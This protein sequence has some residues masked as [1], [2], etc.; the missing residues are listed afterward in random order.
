MFDT[1]KLQSST[2]DGSTSSVTGEP[3]FGANDP[4]SELNPSSSH[5]NVRAWASN[6]AKVTL[7]GGSQFRRMGVCFQNL[8]AFGFITPADYQKDVANIWLALPGM[9]IRN[10]KRV[11]ILHQFDGIIRP[12]EMCVVLGPP[13]SGCSTFLKTLSGDRDGFFIGEDSYFNYEGIS[14]KELHTAHRGDAI[15]T[16]ET[17]VHFPKLTVSQTL[18]FAAQA[19]CPREIPQG[20]PRQQFCKQLKDVVMGMYGISHTADTKVGNDYIRGVSGG[21]RKRVTIAEATLS[22]APLQCWDN[23]TRGL[24]SANAIGFCKTLRLQSEF[25]GQS[26]AVS[27]YQAPQSAYDLFD[28]ATVLYQGHQIYFGPADEAKAYFE[29]LGFECPSRQTTPDFLTSMTFPEERITRAG[30]NPPR[31]PEEFAAA[32]RS[33]PEYKAL[34]TDISEYKTKHPIDGPNAGV[35]RELKKSY[36]A[37]GQRIKSPY[38]L[39]YMQQVQMCMR[40]AWNRLVSDPGPTIVVTM[41]N[42]VLALIMSSLFFNMQPDTDSFYGREVVLFMAVMFNAFASV[43]EVMTLYAQR[44]IV[45]KQARYAFYHPSAEAYSSVLMDLPIKVLACVSFNL[46]FYFMTNLNRTPGNFFF[47]LLASFFIVLSM[48]GIFRFIKIPSAAFSR[49]VQQAM[50]P[51]SILMVFLIT[52]AGFMVPINYMLPWCR[53]INYLNPVAYGFESLMIN[54]YAGREFR[55]SNY[56]P[57]DGTPGDPNVACNVVGAVAGETFVSGDAHIS[58]AY[59]YDAAHKWRN[60]GIVIAMTIFNYTMCFI[61]SEYVSA[62]KSKGEILVFRRGFVPKNTHVNK[63]TDDLEARSLPVTKIVESPEGSKEK[64]GGELQSGSTSIFHWRNVCYDIKIKGKPRRILDNVDGWVKPGTMTALMGVSGAGKTTLLDCLADRRTGIGIITGEMLVDGKIRDE[65]FQRKTGYAQQQDLHLETATVR[66]SLVFSALLRRPH[67]IPKAEKLAYVEEVIDLLEMGPYADAVVGVLG[68]GLN[69]EQRKRLTIAVE[70]AAKPPLLL[71]VDE[72]TSGLDS[73]TSWAVVN[74][75]EKLSKAGQSILCTLHQPSAMLFQRFDRLLL[76]A[77]GGKTVYFGDIGENSSTLVEYFERK[78]KHPCPPNANPAEWML[79]AIGAAPG[80]TSE[81][82]WQHVWRTSPE[83]DRVQ[84]ELSRL[85]EHG[86]QSNSHDSEKSETKAV[87]YH[88]EFAVPLWTQFVVVIERV[89]QQSWRTPAYIYSRF[90]LCGV[91]SLFIGLVFLN[92][93]LSVRGLQNQM[94]AVFQLFAIVGQLVSQ[95]MPQFIIQRSLYEVRERP[96][97]TYSWKVFMVSQI[98]S[99]IPYYALASVMMWALWYFPIGLYKNA[100]VAGQETERGA[101]MWLLFLAWLMWVSTFGHFCISFSETAEAGANAANFMYV[102]V[103]FF[104][105][106]LITPNQMPRFWIFLYRASPLS[107]LVSS[108]L[109]AGIAN[110]EVT[111]AAN[112]YT[113]IDPPMGQTCYEYLRNEINTIGGYLLDNN[114]TENCKFCKLKYSN[115]FLS[116]IEIEYG[117]RWRNFGIIWVYVIFN[118]S[119]AITLYWVARMPKGHRKV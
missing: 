86:S 112:E 107:Y 36:Q 100:E 2:Q 98:L 41:G 24:D 56:I 77:D 68:E 69:V 108:M 66:E 60:I 26:C 90:A 30:F 117:T 96:A 13:S 83:F 105:G 103:N 51:A 10:R 81:V 64:V 46:V 87:T 29:R 55:C 47:Y 109:S 52:F 3:I 21:E 16:A 37:R 85:R 19:R 32:W 101:L 15:Y 25:F 91:V 88:G 33:S 17:D 84:E 59:S 106:A 78:A 4:N 22:N 62:K 63:I 43:L 54:E 73:Q 97:K 92:S 9:L 72:P 7:E 102:L 11:N 1:T 119:A 71:F 58:E 61:T 48:S 44:P 99:D 49:T 28:K 39:T 65:S 111:C 42:F 76:L 95:Q 110:V 12:G 114:A 115:V 20:I 75:L 116:E 94:F 53:W 34:Q 57:F 8:N 14:D 70:L 93:P 67:H 18:E 5:F 118:I 35:Y 50:I 38:T 113:I 27:M 80:T 40:R 45:E 104:C 74:L 82:D 89:F 31:T 6:Y 23:C 79:E